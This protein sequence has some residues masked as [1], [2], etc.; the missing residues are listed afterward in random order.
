METEKK[1]VKKRKKKIKRS[2]RRG[3]AHIQASYNNTIVSITD[4]NGNLVASSS[5]GQ[6]GFK[7]PKKST[8]YAAGI[9]VRSVAEKIKETDRKSVV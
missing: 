7:G 3:Q 1:T 5:A 8:P 6:N 2:L 9:I 4:Q